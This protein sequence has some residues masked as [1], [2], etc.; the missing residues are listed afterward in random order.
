M[1]RLILVNRRNSFAKKAPLKFTSGT[2]LATPENGTIG[3]DGTNYF[4]TSGGNRYTLAKTLTATSTLNFPNTASQGT[5]DLAIT[6]TGAADGDAVSLGIPNAAINANSL[7]TA[8]VSAANTV[9]IRFTNDATGSIDPASAVFR[10]TVI[11][12]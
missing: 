12:Y 7:Y 1:N 3:Y 11:K 8:W 10:T 4:V 9:T 2:N 5:A 6:V